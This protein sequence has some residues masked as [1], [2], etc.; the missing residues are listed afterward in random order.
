MKRSARFALATVLLM[1]A[2]FVAPWPARRAVTPSA[3]A[4]IIEVPT[5]GLTDILKTPSPDKTD[6]GNGDNG[7]DGSGDG[8]SGDDGSGGDGGDDGGIIGGSDDNNG[9]SDGKGGKDDGKPG[10]DGAGKNGKGGKNQGSGLRN[11]G[12]KNKGDDKIDPPDSVAG[13]IPGAYDTRKLVAVAA[14]LRGLGFSPAEVIKRVFP[15]FIIA[16]PA[17]WVDTWGAPRYGPAPGQIRTHE[18]QDVFCDYGDPILAPEP[19]I[20][21]FSDGG[22]GGITARVH[23]SDGSYWYLTHLSD[24]NTEQF[25]IGDHVSTG[26]VLGY[27]GNSGNAATTPPHV[28]FGWYQPNGEAKNPMRPL[29]TWLHTAEKRVLGVVSKKT[30]EKAKNQPI[31]TAARRFGD[32]FVPDRSEFR[33]AGE[34]LWASGSDPAIGTYALAEAALRAALSS[35][36]LDYVPAG[37]PVDLES[38]GDAQPIGAL[39]PDSALARLLE[40]RHA[41]VNEAGD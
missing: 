1:A 38:P 37:Q 10:K 15:P 8:G 6:D 13:H 23:L 25:S 40:T 24:L 7:D 36:G 20:V 29:I 35:Q 14:Q 26:D 22:L 34:S 33:V 19:G 31:Y 18:G 30:A 17:S 27:C 4:G 21:D 41:A 5:P 28:H 3:Q 11:G 9:E 32:S 16:G 12:K 2:L 39:D